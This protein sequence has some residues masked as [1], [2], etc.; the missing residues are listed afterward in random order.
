MMN[1]ASGIAR[2]LG[3]AFAAFS[4][5]VTAAYAAVDIK[6]LMSEVDEMN[7]TV[8]SKLV[9]GRINGKLNSDVAL[10][11]IREHA[12]ARF[13][14]ERI[15]RTAVGKYWKKASEEQRKLLTSLFG[16]LLEK[17]YS[18]TLAKFSDQRISVEGAEKR[19]SNLYSVRLN[20]L[21]EGKEIVIDYLVHDEKENWLIY[22]VKV[23]GI[24]LIASYR[25]Q[26]SQVIRKS[27]VD[28][29]ANLLR[30]RI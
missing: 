28:G 23:E 10:E 8:I 19:N 20:V 7:Q 2:Q 26:F 14:F 30:Q 22:D 3:T 12:S 6:T 1:K 15:T 29:L 24:S 25:N 21:H 27:G 9:A 17:T 18:N 16:Q 11:I 13:D 4:M 5:L